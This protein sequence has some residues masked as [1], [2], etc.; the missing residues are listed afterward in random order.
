[1][2]IS[3]TN[4]IFTQQPRSNISNPYHFFP[5]LF[6]HLFDFSLICNK[7]LGLH[8]FSIGNGNNNDKVNCNDNDND[9]TVMSKNKLL[10]QEWVTNQIIFI[11]NHRW[12]W[13]H[14]S[15]LNYTLTLPL[16]DISLF[17]C[18]PII[19]FLDS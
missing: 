11:P 7:E 13:C 5:F 9:I 12:S 3:K 1:M 8:F 2:R 17:L 10:A 14:Q 15:N 4:F 19:I 6:S 16:I 18:S